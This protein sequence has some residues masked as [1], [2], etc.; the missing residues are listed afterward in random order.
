MSTQIKKTQRVIL[1]LE[2]EDL[3]FFQNY[4]YDNF[5]SRKKTL[6]MFL[7]KIAKQAN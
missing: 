5:M 4:A 6:E 2:K 3:E 7:H 1:D